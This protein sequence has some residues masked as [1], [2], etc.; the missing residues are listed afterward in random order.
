MSPMTKAPLPHQQDAETV[1]PEPP[2]SP[3]LLGRGWLR[4]AL[5]SARRRLPTLVLILAAFA[6]LLF[7]VYWVALR[8]IDGYDLQIGLAQLLLTLL[9]S[10]AAFR[11]AEIKRQIDHTPT[12]KIRS[13]AMGMVEVEGRAKRVYSLVSP[14]SGIPC[15]FYRL[16]KYRMTPLGFWLFQYEIDSSH[17]PFCIEDETGR[18]AVAP[19][20]AQVVPKIKRYGDYDLEGNLRWVET[21]CGDEMYVEEILFENVDLYVLGF[22]RPY[23]Q[24]PDSV[25]QRTREALFQLKH[26]PGAL[27]EFDANRDGRISLEEWDAA[28][29]VTEE[30][31]MAR[32]LAEKSPKA[33]QEDYAI[34]TRPESNSLPFV[35]CEDHSELDMSWRYL[36]ATIGSAVLAL[37]NALGFFAAVSRLGGG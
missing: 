21:P 17:V 29:R 1:L 8:A 22:A 5:Y 11:A 7:A 28:R 19:D 30:Q 14:V 37:V 27:K 13:L 20:W 9:F 12:S 35:I 34:I 25:R 6:S 32:M 31:V 36:V 23:R 10:G 2:L 24:Q 18:V 4:S 15:V 26:R 33:R 16:R 3:G